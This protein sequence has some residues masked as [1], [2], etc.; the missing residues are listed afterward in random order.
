MKV[1]VA[2]YPIGEPRD[3]PAFAEKQAAVL[4]Q[5]VAVFRLENGQQDAAAPL[6]SRLA[7]APQRVAVA[8]AAAAKPAR[9]TAAAPIRN[10]A[11]NT[12]PTDSDTRAPWAMPAAS[13]PMASSFC[14]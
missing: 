11:A 7:P 3:F 4:G 8:P 6:P 14:V 13:W 5:A 9:G 12:T 10:A 2:K 1:A